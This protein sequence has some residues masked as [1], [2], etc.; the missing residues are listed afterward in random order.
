MKTKIIPILAFFL[1]LFACE[2]TTYREYMGNAPVYL[3]FEEFRNAVVTTDTAQLRNPGKIYFKDSYIFII[4][5]LK[6]IHV[7]DNSN[8]AS[9]VKKTFV[10]LPGVIDMV[11]SGNIMYA[12]SFTDLVVLDLQDINNIHEAG[13]IKDAL[14]YT[15]P[16]T[17]NT[18]PNGFIDK[19]K[20]V[21]VGWKL[22]TIK[23]KVYETPIVY[24]YYKAEMN[25]VFDLSSSR[26]YSPSGV[27]SGGVGIGG[28]MARFGIKDN[29]LYLVDNN[30]LSFYDITSPKNPVKAG[31]NYPGWSIETMFIT[32][33]NMFLG[34]TSGMVIIDITSSRNPVRIANY[35]HVRSCD[36]VVVEDTLAYVTLRSGTTCGGSVNSL[37]VIN[38]KNKVSPQLVISYPMTSPY[39]LGKNGNLLFVCE[40][41]FGLKIYD[42]SNPRT[43]TSHLLYGY[44]DIKAFDVIPIGTL[45]VMIGDDGLYQYDC[46]NVN[47]VRLLSTIS[48]VK[49]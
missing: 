49:E 11:I 29:T 3:S 21:V 40:G 10:N 27:S 26:T 12:D 42:A 44:Q 22:G 18:F 17:G 48:T 47:N 36:P 9:P 15:V 35:S 6:G 14:P 37:E 7:Y 32:G 31:D 25:G 34:T 1:I 38:L 28:S 39:G 20:G 4:E 33:N 16:P 41:S 23:E 8:P 46:A 30:K 43:I 19:T 45:L 13:R 5:E 24:Q 2:D